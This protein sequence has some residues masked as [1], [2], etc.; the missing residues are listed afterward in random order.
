M[1]EANNLILRSTSWSSLVR[2]LSGIGSTPAFN[3]FKGDVFERFTEC[4]FKTQPIFSSNFD[5]IWRHTDIPIKVRDF[6]ELPT[7][8]I[9]VDLIAQ[10]RDGTY[11]AIQCKYHQDPS[12]N[13]SY[14]ELSTFF[15]VTERE[16][17]YTKL[18]HR[19]VVTSANKVSTNVFKLHKEK[20]GIVS[21]E[22]FRDLNEECFTKIHQMIEGKKIF[23]LPLKPRFHQALAVDNAEEYF[24]S[25][26]RTRGKIIH[27]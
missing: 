12:I 17:T 10:Y 6:L 15:S 11:C 13:V 26:G 23:F 27:P 22:E 21:G 24:L 2:E 14:D 3:K 8:E 18:S 4:Y 5:N 9:G 19:I 1:S 20:L 25:Q 7:P 16:N